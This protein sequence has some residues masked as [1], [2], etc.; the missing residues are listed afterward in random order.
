MRLLPPLGWE[1]RGPELRGWGRG[2]PNGLS[3][4]KLM[5]KWTYP[6]PQDVIIFMVGGTTY[7]EARAIARLNQELAGQAG[8]S[9]TRVLLG[10]T[11]V[12]NSSRL[13]VQLSH[14]FVCD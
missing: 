9:A 4:L 6:R 1:E 13:V 7:E 2:T 12:H 11:C 14:I 5:T 10:G 3:L 8:G